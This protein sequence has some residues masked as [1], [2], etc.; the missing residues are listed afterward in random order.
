VKALIGRSLDTEDGKH[1]TQAKLVV[2]YA[3]H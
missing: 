1:L 2:E 3:F